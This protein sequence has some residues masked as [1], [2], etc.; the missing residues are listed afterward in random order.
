M[1]RP[2]DD[3]S[4]FIGKKLTFK[5]TKHELDRRGVN[6]VLSR[7]ALLEEEAR[8]AAVETRRSWMVGRCCRARSPPSRTSAPSSDLGGIE[9]ML[10]AS[11]LGF[12][13]GVRPGEVLAVGSNSRCRCCASSAPTIPAAR[14]PS[15]CR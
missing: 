12:T 5:V 7:R 2:V 1:P 11:E 4:S 10:P 3:A 6:L 8:C 15:R 14:A 13:R 9:G